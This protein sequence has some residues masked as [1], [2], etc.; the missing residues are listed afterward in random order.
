[1]DC[2]LNYLNTVKTFLQDKGLSE[3]H[4]KK[5]MHSKMDSLA[6]NTVFEIYALY[7]SEIAGKYGWL[8]KM[9]A[10]ANKNCDAPFSSYLKS[11]FPYIIGLLSKYTTLTLHICLTMVFG[12]EKVFK[13]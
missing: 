1:M 12:G 4:S 2:Y 7:R 11:G 8:K 13:K 10:L 6:Y 3:E 9:L 5:I